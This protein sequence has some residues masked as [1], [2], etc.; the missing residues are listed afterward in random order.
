MRRPSAALGAGTIAALVLTLVPGALLATGPVAAAAAPDRGKPRTGTVVVTVKAPA[1]VPGVVRL[2]SGAKVRVVAK[3]PAG[4]TTRV[5]LRLPRGRWT[6]SAAQLVDDSRLYTASVSRKRL[7]VNP[8]RKTALT[9]TYRRAPSV[10]GLQVERVEPTVVGLRW[11]APAGRAASYQVR[12]ASGAQPPAGVSGGT[13]V[14][15]T[16]AT[17]LDDD[18]DP[19]TTYAFSVF[20]RQGKGRWVGPVSTTVTTPTGGAGTEQ[21]STVTNPATV[22]VTDPAAVRPTVVAGGVQTTVPAGVTPVLG[23]PWILPPDT[24]IPTGYLGTVVAVAADGRSVTLA[25][26]GLADVFDYADL[27]V[28]DLGEQAG[29]ISG[30][31]LHGRGAGAQAVIACGG[32]LSE[33][34]T[35]D[36]TFDPYGRFSAKLAKYR[37]FG[38]SIPKGVSFDAE[39][40]VDLGV[41]ATAKVTAGAS[42]QIDI[43]KITIPFAIG[44][45]PMLY[46]L[47]PT[48]GG[49]VNGSFDVSGLGF[50][51]RLGAEFDGYLGI[52][53]DELDGTLIADGDLSEPEVTDVSGSLSLTAGMSATLG[54]G[55]GN[56]KAGAVIGLSATLNPLDLSAS[57]YLGG[58]T[59]LEISAA[60]TASITV[61][62]K[63]W[64][65]NWDYSRS[66]PVP[67][68]DEVVLDYGGSP[69]R[70]P[71]GCGGPAEYRI[72]EGTLGVDWTWSASCANDQGSC[73]DGPDYTSSF[74][75][76]ESSSA[77]L[78]VAT[79]GEW[80]TQ[81]DDYPTYLTAPMAFDSWSFDAT[82]T[83]RQSGW[84]CSWT[85]T[86][87]T[88]GPV[89]FGGAYWQTGAQVLPGAGVPD[90]ALEDYY[91]WEE[92]PGEW[93]SAWWGSLGAWDTDFSNEYPRIPVRSSWVSGGDCEGSSSD[94]WDHNLEWLAPG[95]LW[96]WPEEARRASR[97]SEATELEGCTDELCRWR[98]D[99]SDTY[100]YRSDYDDYGY[101]GS[102]SA[103]V[104]WSYVIE[105]RALE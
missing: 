30:R 5:K 42:C 40:G 10:T 55:S 71:S 88:T 52:G 54:V 19:G 29:T 4:T 28:P 101:Q 62:A 66:V 74:T 13:A 99:G 33:K 63:A 78:H 8:A 7:R 21:A 89:E 39:V 14:P 90:V 2:R 57:P 11:T 75:S 41:A 64:L 9:V 96:S 82:K 24:G 79:P 26:A 93:S 76:S 91:Y 18:L 105:R 58:G 46:V 100:Q 3:K 68:L 67:G 83:W 31:R 85:S 6:V 81:Y 104:T 86:D 69:W 65:G 77:R 102:G 25:A 80:G 61:E 95:Y 16:G 73:D 38:K 37:I 35:I 22:T 47:Q 51:A 17:A 34:Y 59:C 97:T 70:V 12:R 56:P 94:E 98:V 49:S 84:G 72:A 50:S 20:A 43:A 48:I 92:D 87:E 1:G 45:V 60:R 36:P 27:S 53:D 23:Q 32:Q 15:V 44:P 103:T